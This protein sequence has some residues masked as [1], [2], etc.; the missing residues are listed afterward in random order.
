[1]TAMF[2]RNALTKQRNFA[3]RRREIPDDCE[4]GGVIM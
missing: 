3:L 1:M 4:T 2:R